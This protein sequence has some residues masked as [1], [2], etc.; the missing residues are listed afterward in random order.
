MTSDGTNF[1]G[2]WGLEERRAEVVGKSSW[3][4]RWILPPL[5]EAIGLRGETAGEVMA[6]GTAEFP[7]EQVVESSEREI[8]DN[9]DKDPEGMK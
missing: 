3:E 9:R 7:S 6:S 5:P 8:A 2:S 1:R 4:A